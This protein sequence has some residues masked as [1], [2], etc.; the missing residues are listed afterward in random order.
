[1]I[2][3]IRKFENLHIVLWLLKDTCWVML[4]KPLGMFMIVPTLSLAFYITWL[5]RSERAELFHNLAVCSWITANSVW[6]TGEFFYGDSWRSAASVFFF[7]GFFF[8][9]WYYASLKFVRKKI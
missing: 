5:M 7:T 4:W 2:N 9:T 8:V 1:M 6:M 3:S